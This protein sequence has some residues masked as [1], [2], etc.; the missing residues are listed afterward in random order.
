MN[1]ASL[2]KSINQSTTI[3]FEPLRMVI[4]STMKRLLGANDGYGHQVL[5]EAIMDELNEL[6]RNCEVPEGFLIATA[7]AFGRLQDLSKDNSRR[8]R[9]MREALIA[10]LSDVQSYFQRMEE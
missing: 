5:R 7:E 4:G 3:G 2:E 10:G 9:V 1:T 6:A 8:H